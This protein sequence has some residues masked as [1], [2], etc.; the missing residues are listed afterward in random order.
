MS[1][2]A[3][4]DALSFAP[5]FPLSLLKFADSFSSFLFFFFFF[6]FH[7]SVL[8]LHAHDRKLWVFLAITFFH[9]F[10]HNETNMMKRII[11]VCEK[12]FYFEHNFPLSH[13]LSHFSLALP[14]AV[15][16]LATSVFIIRQF[17]QTLGFHANVQPK[18]T[19]QFL[20]YNYSLPGDVVLTNATTYT[21]SAERMMR[22]E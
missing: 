14:L 13:S 4:H 18:R 9:F 12:F 6:I 19:L 2:V 8:C 11:Y 7:S 20:F 3:R 15:F 22:N 1:S 21:N 16:C 5:F 10:R 17:A